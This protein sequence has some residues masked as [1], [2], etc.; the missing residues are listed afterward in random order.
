MTHWHALKEEDVFQLLSSSPSGLTEEEVRKRLESYGPNELKEKKKT[1]LWARFLDQFKSPLI[2]VLLAAILISGLLSEVLDALVISAIVLLN[3]IL[4]LV[5]EERAEQALRTLKK[6]A[7][8]R[9]QVIREGQ[10]R[11]VKSSE[12]V[13]GDIIVLNSGNRVPADARIISSFN[14]MT[15]ESPLTGESLPVEK[16]ACTLEEETPLG[17]RKNMVFAGTTVT[18]G[19]GQ[20]V[21]VSTG[22]ATEIGKIARLLE[23][24]EKESTPL[25]KNLDQVGKLLAFMVLGICLLVFLVGILRGASPLFMLL[26]SISLAVAAIPEGLPAVVTIV[27]ALGT[28][29]MAKRGAIIRHLPAVETL[30]STSIICSDKTGTMTLNEMTAE[31]IVTAQEEFKVTGRGYQPIGKVI[32]KEGDLKDLPLD[33]KMLLIAGAL[34]TDA[35]L[36]QEREKWEIRGDPT[37][38]ALV[39]LASKMGLNKEK[40][41]SEYHRVQEIPFT[42]ERKMMTTVYEKDGER[43]VFSKG[44]ADVLVHFCNRLQR[45]KE[46]EPLNQEGKR[47]ILKKNERM[48]REGLRVLGIAYKPWKENEDLERNLI[49]LGLVGMRDAPREEV[50]EAIATCRKAGIKP[51]MIT[52]DHLLTAV[53][54]GSDLGL[55]QKEDEAITGEELSR[56]SDQELLQKAPILSIYARVLPEDK[57]RILTAYQSM[58]HVVAMT[59]D[60]INDAPALKQA[61][62]GVAMGITGTDVSKESADMVLTDDNFATIVKAVE[63]GR[64]I[65]T[66][67]KKFVSFLLS[68]NLAEVLAVFLGFLL[69]PA[70]EPILTPAQILWMNLVTDGLPALALGVD[71]PE[72]GIMNQKPRSKKTGIFTKRV[73]WKLGI[74]AILMALSTIGAFIFGLRNSVAEGETMAFT[75][76][77]ILELLFSFYSRSDKLPGWKSG[78]ATNKY[79]FWAVLSSILLQV[80]IIYT[81]GVSKAFGTVPLNLIDWGLIAAISFLNFSLLEVLKVFLF[82]QI[83]E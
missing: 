16:L 33:L 77:V 24:T 69:F 14:L 64:T 71:P 8:P 15:D 44:A 42:S 72:E 6:M 82:S 83:Q 27:L 25:Q 58:G 76:I 47:I 21:V 4:G 29:R 75:T 53:A 54:I 11:E 9:C 7:V 51:V 48:A 28:Q 68:C 49:F 17:E 56:L 45:G 37:E 43:L 13:P 18:Y 80:L 73:L 30:G 23:E 50:R 79:L 39:V 81:P 10:I 5:Q 34:N 35:H 59:G 3:A 52:G 22:M 41:L 38:G 2:I 20:A 40:L 1:P 19:R 12:I 36:V 66:N 67:I 31:F 63:E 61:N 26:L 32:G 60:G 65:F 74:S 46:V 78:L 57:V 62:I 55:I 70:R